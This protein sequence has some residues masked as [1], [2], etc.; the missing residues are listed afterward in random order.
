MSMRDKTC[1][2]YDFGLFTEAAVRLAR[3]L[4]KV[5]YFVPWASAFPK[6]NS[7]MIGEG[8]DGLERVLDFWDYVDKV[9][10]IFIPDTHCG[11]IVEFLKKK[12]YKVAGVGKAE[13]LELDRWYGRQ[14]QKRLGLPT[15]KTAKIKGV[16]KLR[17]YLT[18]LTDKFVKFN[19]FRGEVESFKHTDIEASTPLL[20]HLAHEFGAKQNHIEFIVED[21]VGEIEP[22]A[23]LIVFKDHY[24]SPTMWGYE[25]KGMGYFCKVLPYKELPVA[26]KESTDALLEDFSKFNTR[27]FYSSE[28]R[29][30]KDRKSYLI[31]NTC[32]FAAPGVGAVQ[33]ELI[34]NFT[35]VIWGL[36][37]GKEIQPIMKYK[38]AGAICFES[39]WAD[40]HWL[41]VNFPAADRKWIKFRMAAKFDGEYYAVPG[42]SSVCTVI[43]LGNTMKDVKELIKKRSKGINAYLLDK[44]LSGLEEIDE[45]IAEGE[46]FGI[47]W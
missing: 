16:G 26:M 23:D 34:D 41:K 28:V 22:G 14:E 8:L 17:D 6:S 39:E 40:K 24:L 29:V 7:A 47:K 4:K 25:F 18:P 13:K 19:I 11:D 33:T 42:F 2:V 12:G 43:A 9:D 36:A 31:D 20:D 30:G 44:N 10:F 32:R 15:Q 21:I 37:T 45:A 46:K 27:F 1:L 3:D 5:Y 38:Y 35:E